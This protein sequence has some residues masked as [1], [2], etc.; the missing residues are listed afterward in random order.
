MGS[1]SYKGFTVS[2]SVKDGDDSLGYV[3]LSICDSYRL[4][5][6]GDVNFY[7]SWSLTQQN[8]YPFC[9]YP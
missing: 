3:G 6:T 2:F 8:P 4:Y 1:V 9:S 7:E 5:T